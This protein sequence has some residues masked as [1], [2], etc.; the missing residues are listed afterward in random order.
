MLQ[1]TAVYILFILARYRWVLIPVA[2]VIEVMR[3][4]SGAR[5]VGLWTLAAFVFCVFSTPLPNFVLV[6]WGR[7]GT[8]RV[9]GTYGDRHAGW[10]NFRVE[11]KTNDGSV[12]QVRYDNEDSELPPLSTDWMLRLGPDDQFNVRYLAFS[13]EHF[14]A[15]MDDASPWARREMCRHLA[16]ALMDRN[17]YLKDDDAPDFAARRMDERRYEND[18]CFDVRIDMWTQDARCQ[19]LA[20]RQDSPVASSGADAVWSTPGRSCASSG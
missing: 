11:L 6:N 14:A 2:L 15:L 9:V 5:F 20:S 3:G 1:D 18:R 12:H 17:A 7:P 13:P 10:S 19:Y 4:R 16:M 8:A